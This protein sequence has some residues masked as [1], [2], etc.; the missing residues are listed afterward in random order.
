MKQQIFTMMGRVVPVLPPSSSSCLAGMLPEQTKGRVFFIILLLLSRV[1]S[2]K[3]K[4]ERDVGHC[5]PF[6]VRPGSIF[7]RMLSIETMTSFRK[8][9]QLRVINFILSEKEEEERRRRV[10]L[11]ERGEAPF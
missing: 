3:K 5:L 2:L 8:E 7:R 6:L 10:V 1:I 4:E 11:V 9:E